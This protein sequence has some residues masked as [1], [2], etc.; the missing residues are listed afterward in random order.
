MTMQKTD[1]YRGFNTQPPKGGWE[2]RQ[3]DYRNQW[4]FNTQPPKG[5]WEQPL[6]QHGVKKCFNTQP[7]KGGW[8][9]CKQP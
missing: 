6:N 1:D 2:V 3:F 7:P 4:S 9:G 5:G 8:V